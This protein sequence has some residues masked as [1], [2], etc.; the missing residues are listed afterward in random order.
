MPYKDPQKARECSKRSSRRRRSENPERFR[1]N[2]RRYAQANRVQRN[3]KQAL[4]YYK[5]KYGLTR[6]E[7]EAMITA[8]GFKC[9]VCEVENPE[10]HTDHCHVSGAVRGILCR[11]CN[12]MLGFAKDRPDILRAGAAYLERTL[13]K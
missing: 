2:D 6:E 7:V 3:E 11:L 9:A 1:A 4:R 13:P 8:Q 5:R 10:W 12:S